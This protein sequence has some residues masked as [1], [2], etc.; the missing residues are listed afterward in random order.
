M[1]ELQISDHEIELTEK[2]L[3]S[4][5]AHFPDD[6]RNVIRCWHSTDVAACPGSGKTTVLLAKLKLLADRMPLDNGS[7]ICVLSHTN[8]AVDEIKKRLSG[9]ADRLL[10]YPNFVGTIQAFVDR[11][12]TMP[13]LKMVSGHSVQPVDD[14]TYAQHLLVKMQNQRKYSDL[15]SVTKRNY[16]TVRQYTS[17]IDH[18]QALYLR[19]DGALCVGNQKRAL[20]GAQKQSTEQYIAL[21]ADLRNNDGIIRYKDA[22]KYAEAAISEMIE[23]YTNLFLMRFTYVFIDEYQDCDT[24]QRRVIDLL[25]NPEKCCLMKIGDPDQAIY[26]SDDNETT[27][28]V[29]KEGYLPIMSSCRYGQEIA[30]VISRLKKTKEGISSIVRENCI[31]PVLLVFD[32]DSIDQVLDR[33]IVELDKHEMI[34]ASGLYKAIGAV[35]KG[36]TTGLRIGSYWNGFDGSKKAQAEN[37][38]WIYIDKI[39]AELRAG[40][41]YLAEYYIRKLICRLFYYARIKHQ[42]T[43]NVFT[44]STLKKTLDEEYRDIYRKHIFGLSQVQMVDRRLLDVLIRSLIR[45]LVKCKNPQAEDIFQRLPA[46]FIEDTILSESKNAAGESN[47]FIDLTRR[48]KI[49]FNTIHGVKGETHDATLYLETDRRGAS[50]LKRVLPFFGVGNVG[51]S[52]LYD[53]SRK[54]AY[55]GMSRPRKLLCVAMQYETYVSSKGTFDDG[56]EVIDLRK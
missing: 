47:V 40:K 19:G 23:A 31:K 17:R 14:L 10:S 15:E 28:W 29:P 51:E 16:E 45:E 48:R 3:L 41:I 25:F 24:T 55:V 33:F 56:W 12:V 22:Y 44:I 6:A 38:Y 20:A 2:L 21:I 5:G 54:L 36:S 50:D 8:V 30:D 27:D 18:T 26:N 43:G 35:G 11:F 49:E 42:S 1:P 4:E 32:M 52:S 7:G 53:Y 46:H 37:K 34:E 9:Y 39:C 13:Y